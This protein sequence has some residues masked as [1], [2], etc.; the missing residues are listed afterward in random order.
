M[1]LWQFNWVIISLLDAA[2]DTVSS[3]QRKL[4]TELEALLMDGSFH[5]AR[6]QF[7]NQ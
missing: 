2:A 4:L 7:Q 6:S 1:L 5:A 3:I